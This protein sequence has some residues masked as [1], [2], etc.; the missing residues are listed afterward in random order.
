MTTP[1]S[2]RLTRGCGRAARS[3]GRVALAAAHSRG[4][5]SSPSGPGPGDASPLVHLGPTRRSG[6]PPG[7]DTTARHRALVVALPLALSLALTTICAPAR[8]D[9]AP[10]PAPDT[11]SD[12]ASDTATKTAPKTAPSTA[13]ETAPKTAPSVSKDI[14]RPRWIHLHRPGRGVVELGLAV[15]ALLPSA[16][17]ELY[18]Y[19]TPWQ[20]R[21]PAAAAFALRAGYYPLAFIGA[22]AE[23]GLA[24]S[25][26]TDGGRAPILGVRGHLVGQL[27]FASVAPFALVG[28]GFLATRNALG[29]DLD[30]S[31]HVGGGLK[32]FATRWLG[33]RVD[34][35]AHVGLAHTVEAARAFHPE[36][37]ASF[38]VTLLRPYADRDGDGLAD[39]GQ[40][41]P[42]E[43]LCPGERGP[44]RLH[45]CPDRDHD[46]IRD[47]DDRCPDESGLAARD[48]CPA[49]RD[50]DS[51]G[52]FDP[53]QYKIPEG[54]VD[55]CPAEPGVPEYE[56]C[57]APDTDGDGFDDLAD[58]C[59][60]EPETVNGFE[61]DDG[62]PDAIPLDVQRI[63]GTIRG[64]QFG[65]LSDQ[66]T[67][68]STPI[69]DRAAAILTEYPVLKLEIQG[70]TDTDGD[71]EDNKAL[72]LRRAESVR[73]HLIEAG[74]AEERLRAV[75]YGGEAPIAAHETWEGRAA[76][77]RIEF[78]LLDA[79]GKPLAVAGETTR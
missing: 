14:P 35:R 29:S 32:I 74:V 16:E 22:E 58:R 2:K 23:G 12:T 13:P 36:V 60:D 55:R 6:G 24:L 42:S 7:T 11:A 44:I 10:A 49:L 77:R 8:V 18:D 75:G 39:P 48:G 52:F 63:L 68:D 79:T 70:H 45:G 15:G 76:N 50:G 41:A 69:L 59:R 31:L 47:L 53:D 40:K 46:E 27:P 73:R 71:P 57:A 26:T 67:V 54:R 61:D 30:P 3:R 51:D 37:L 21:R 43:D 33:V 64:V 66:L 34:A 20:A 4:S 78:R 19:T 5:A 1:R 56:G 9:A 65:F 62:C 72:S 25:R 17:H 38:I 28:G